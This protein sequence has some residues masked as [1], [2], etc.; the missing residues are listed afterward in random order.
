MASITVRN[1]DEGVKTRLRVRAARRGRSMED[2]AREIL[3]T[4][5]ATAGD[6]SPDLATSICRR[7]AVIGGV[8]LDIPPREPMREPPEVGR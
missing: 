1:L 7:F 2:E 5:L 4:A 3:R 8:E 6:A